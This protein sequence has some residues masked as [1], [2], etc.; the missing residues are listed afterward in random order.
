M[1]TKFSKFLFL[2]LSIFL[3]EICLAQNNDRV[4]I[5]TTGANGIIISAADIEAKSIE[6]SKKPKQARIMKELETRRRPKRN[7]AAID[8]AIFPFASNTNNKL[9]QKEIIGTEATQ[10]IVSNFLGT[11]YSESGSV[12][13]DCMGDVGTTQVCIASNGRLKFYNKNT[14][15][16]AALTTPLGGNSTPLTAPAYSVDL[17]VFFASVVTTGEF[18]SDPHVRFD[19]ATNKWFIVAIDVKATSNRCL[20]AVSNGPTISALSNFTFFFFTFD[21]LLPVPA[22]PYLGGFFDYPTLGIDANA[23]YIGSAMFNGAGTAYLGG[24]VFVVRKS[25]ILGTGPIVTTA[26]HLLGSNSTGI[27][28]AQGVDNDDPAA[29]VGYVIGVD[30]GVFSSL[31]LHRITNPGGIPIASAVIPITVTTTSSPINQVSSGTTQTMDAIDDRLYAAMIR[32]NKITGVSSLWTA[33]TNAVNTSGISTSGAGVRNGARWYQIDNYTATPT[34]TQSGTVFDNAAATPKGYWFPSIATSGQG[35]SLISFSSAASN[36]FAN[37]AVAGR[38]RTDVLGTQQPV[39][40]ATASSTRYNPVFDNDGN[41]NRWGDYSQVGVDP[42]D[43]M[44]MWTFQE[45]CSTQDIWGVRAIQVKAPAPATPIALG[46]INCGTGPL[47][48]TRSSSISLT[49]T[50]VSNSEFYDAGVGFNRLNVTTTGAGITITNIVFVNPTQITFDINWP[51]TLANTTQTLT[52]TNPDCQSVATT[53]TLPSSCSVV[54]LDFISFYGKAIDKKIQLN[55]TTENQ[56]NTNTFV[57]EKKDAQ[58]NFVAIGSVS[59]S[60]T[61]TGEYTFL[62]ANLNEVN[63]YRIKQIDA[64]GAFKYSSVVIINVNKKGGFIMYPNPANSMVTLEYSNEYKNHQIKII[65]ATGKIV[66]L[67]KNIEPNK[68]NVDIA[69]LAAGVYLIQIVNLNSVVVQQEKLLVERK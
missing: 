61:N 68:T 69:K 3:S 33:H 37:A 24:S 29:S 55:W 27:Y 49:G 65:D 58:N 21:Q 44:T 54:P 30:A 35:H 14:V 51:T 36:Q 11:S 66:L 7:D 5:P 56:Q 59:A 48:G 38:Y 40:E 22:A 1:C 32:K 9:E 12:P 45:Y 41:V 20:I 10:S 62:D 18:V 60:N 6:A 31:N 57:I 2:F 19:K 52:V 4:G 23:L 28:I 15:C 53:Y 64:N 17:E 46:T 34:I 43:D 26:F 39:V 25:S 67:K 8:A 13:P 16:Q 47:V 42:S 63:T 50:S